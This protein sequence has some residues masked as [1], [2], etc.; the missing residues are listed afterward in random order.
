MKPHPKA[1]QF[2]DEDGRRRPYVISLDW[3]SLRCQKTLF[4]QGDGTN[5]SGYTLRDELKH[6]SRNWRQIR[7]VYDPDGVMIGSLTFDPVSRNIDPDM[8]VFKAENSLLYEADAVDRICAAVLGLGL[9]YKAIARLDVA[10]DFNEF[11]NGLQAQRFF[12][13]LWRGEYIKVGLA[14]EA[15]AVLDFGYSANINPRDGEL[16]VTNRRPEYLNS[17]AVN[18]AHRA[19]L[20]ER[21]KDIA[22]SGLQPLS[23]EPIQQLHS[24]RGRSRINALTWGKTGRAIQV[25]MYNKTKELREVKMKKW[26]VDT[27]QA[28]GLDISRDVWRVEMRIQLHGKQIINCA[29]GEPFALSL[30]DLLTQEQVSEIFRAYA[31]KYFKFY[32]HE[33][34]A[35]IQNST[36]VQL[37]SWCEP[38]V[39]RPKRTAKGS[40]TKYIQGLC[41]RI[42]AIGNEAE[43]KG[44]KEV[45]NA[46]HVLSGVMAKAYGMSRLTD[47]DIAKQAFD[48]G[49]SKQFTMPLRIQGTLQDSGSRTDAIIAR[50]IR[51]AKE[52][53][54]RLFEAPP[55]DNYEV[56]WEQLEHYVR[57]NIA[58]MVD[59]IEY[60]IQEP[61]DP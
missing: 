40:P 20:E 42:I 8:V 5:P 31:D 18:N 58:H 55:P 45:A 3:L 9:E 61:I 39:M 1:L 21:N 24:T 15:F 28:A 27:W 23:D 12:D 49:V 4:F 7:E 13:H 34:H 14:K 10:C 19:Y 16:V 47:E 32:H 52:V 38:P 44:N 59:P 33:G 41:N 6:G 25:Q 35:K 26:I 22:G 57:R 37:F 48:S 2:S 11:F 53:K 51:R 43:E 30:V 56:D 60:H 29:T 46:A 54:K 50:A 17:D 36:P